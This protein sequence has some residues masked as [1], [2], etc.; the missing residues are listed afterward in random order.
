MAQLITHSDYYKYPWD[1]SF[2]TGYVLNSMANP[3]L[4]WETTEQFDLGIDLG[5][6]KGRI[7]LTLDYYIKTT[8]D[9][10][11]NAEVPASSGYATATLNIGK[12]RNKG[13]EITLESTN[14]TTKD[15]TWS[16][17]FNIAFNNNEIIALNSGQKEMLSYVRWDNAYNNMPAYISRVGESAGKL[18]GYIYE[19]TYKYDDFNQT[20]NSDGSISYKLKDGIPRISD[21]VQPGD[22]RYKKLSND[23]TNKITDDDRTIIGNGQP[24]HTGGFT[25]NFVYKNWDLNIFLQWSYGNDILNANRMV[26]E[27]PSNRTNTNMF[28]SYNNRWNAANPTSDMPRAKALDAKHYSSLYVEDGSFLKLK[29]I[30][31]G[32]NLGRKALYKLGIQA[33]R[34]YFSAEN[35]ATLSGYSG[36]DPEVSVRNSVLTPGFDWSSCPRSFNASFGVN[37]TF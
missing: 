32:Y 7:N 6:L 20:T 21:S 36:S 13:F 35:I 15:F 1:S 16:S 33:A 8:K 28:A 11:L 37:I 18:Y 10:L 34:V 19:G 26:F 22:P 27:N 23:G 25:N 5:F 4:K 17:N 14:I 30:S 29:T 9:L 24:K 3:S 12:L 2:T 31:L